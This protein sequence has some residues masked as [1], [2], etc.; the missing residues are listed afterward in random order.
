[1]ATLATTAAAVAAAL[2][3]APT[4]TAVPGDPMPGCET[5]I[6]A[7]Y[8]DGPIRED[9][10]WKRCLMAHG[11]YIGNIYTPPVQN[12]FIIPGADQIPPTPL[13][14]PNYHIE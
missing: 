2:A 12:C 11:Q 13:G 10:S 7:N 5:Q 1:M 4:A 9:G 3:A 6:F 8:C 14:Q